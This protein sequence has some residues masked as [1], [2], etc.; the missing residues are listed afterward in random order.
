MSAGIIAGIATCIGAGI[1]LWVLTVA[2]P[3]VII[4]ADAMHDQVV[5]N[6]DVLEHTVYQTCQLD[7]AVFDALSEAIDDPDLRYTLA[8]MWRGLSV[9][10]SAV[11]TLKMNTPEKVRDLLPKIYCS[12]ITD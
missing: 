2:A 4:T 3:P 8:E 6:Q 12:V 10:E 11:D 9:T 1:A 5:K 7:D